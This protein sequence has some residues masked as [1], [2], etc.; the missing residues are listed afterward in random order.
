M[1]AIIIPEGFVASC[2][3][4]EDR[5]GHG[6]ALVGLPLLGGY[7][8][9]VLMD[10]V[11]QR[12]LGGHSHHHHH[13]YH[14]VAKQSPRPNGGEDDALDMEAAAAAAAA[15]LVECLC[16]GDD[17]DDP[18]DPDLEIELPPLGGGGAPRS[19]TA[20]A[21]GG[22]GVTVRSPHRRH[23]STSD[24][25][26]LLPL[27]AAAAAGATHS[28]A[29]H[30]RPHQRHPRRPPPNPAARASR[31]CPFSTD[32]VGLLVH[33]LA[34][35]VALGA[36]ALSNSAALQWSVFS[37][38]SLHKL[39]TAFATGAY[40]HTSLAPNSTITTTLSSSSSH[41][42]PRPPSSNRG[43][44]PF[45]FLLH[46]L[47]FALASPFAALATHAAAR[48][49]AAGKADAR[50]IGALLLFSGGSFLFVA[51]GHIAP[52]VL[53]SPHVRRPG[54]RGLCVLLALLGG[55]GLVPLLAALAPEGGEEGH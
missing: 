20:A 35:G 40:V 2:S 7:V 11:G 45:P 43:E 12:L 42:R 33:C 51:V 30:H 39:P 37:A 31:C 5:H 41:Q 23:S 19:P 24:T 1:L 52:E 44:L 4:D 47:A 50:V 53:H 46:A 8:T 3:G 16:D 32:F 22:S 49:L 9:Q 17:D 48:A 21:T 10:V 28:Y 26:G 6:D 54:P 25:T 27:A 13:H 15:E 36:S 38:L 18:N 34:D 29:P 55:V 14:A